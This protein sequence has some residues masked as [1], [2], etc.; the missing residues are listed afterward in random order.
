MVIRM[1]LLQ[2]HS[3]GDVIERDVLKGYLLLDC[4]KH[5]YNICHYNCCNHI[6]RFYLSELNLLGPVLY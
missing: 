6:L 2:G 4:G 3:R 5:F 1:D